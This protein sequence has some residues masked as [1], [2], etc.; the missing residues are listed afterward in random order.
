MWNSWVNWS[1]KSL[2]S[3]A[4]RRKTQ[5]LPTSHHC[6]QC[7]RNKNCSYD[8]VV[9]KC[10]TG[11]T[12]QWWAFTPFSPCAAVTL[13]QQSMSSHP[14]VLTL[15]PSS[16]AATTLSRPLLQLLPANYCCLLFG[17]FK[18]TE[19]PGG[20]LLQA[21][22]NRNAT[23]ERVARP[24]GAA[25]FSLHSLLRC[26]PDTCCRCCLL[27]IV[28]CRLA[29]IKTAFLQAIMPIAS[30][31]LCDALFCKAIVLWES[32]TMP[33]AAA[34]PIAVAFSLQNQV[35]QFYTTTVPGLLRF[36]VLEW[37][38]WYS[39]YPK[40]NTTPTIQIPK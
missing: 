36:S 39:L 14:L 15:S 40:N 35:L 34:M 23:A 31:S 2:P 37:D 11:T 5:L 21:A 22:N 17:I 24:S 38:E 16:L 18:S 8:T 6:C 1:T 28:S 4:Q 33:T 29:F 10:S 26:C 7:I 19:L 12:Q 30:T 13:P 3:A 9:I 20:F 25:A 32:S 27:I